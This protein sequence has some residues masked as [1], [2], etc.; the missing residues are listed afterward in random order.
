MT[1]TNAAVV[2]GLLGALYGEAGIPES[3]REKVLNFDCAAVDLRFE[4]ARRPANISVKQHFDAYLA[5]M[6]KRMPRPNRETG[7]LAVKVHMLEAS[8]YERRE[9]GRDAH[10]RLRIRV[11]NDARQNK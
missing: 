6:L 4:N 7:K 5:E 11:L 1:T 2:G 3:M 10:E 8:T 9:L